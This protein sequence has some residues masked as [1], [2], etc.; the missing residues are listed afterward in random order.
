VSQR[1]ERRT[2]PFGIAL[3]IGAMLTLALFRLPELF[4]ARF[5]R[6][7]ALSFGQAGWAFRFL[8]MAALAQ[9]AYGGFVVLRTERVR[10]AWAARTPDRPERDGK[11]LS[12]ARV[13]RS[14]ASTAASMIFLTFVYGIAAFVVT[15]ER[16][17]YWLFVLIALG[18]AAWYFRRVGEIVTWLRFQPEPAYKDPN[19]APWVREPPDYCPPLTRGLIAPQTK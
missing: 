13:A 4:V 15:A 9:A 18:Q 17:G 5:E 6:E 8:V 16:G 19:K 3:A 11:R 12:R 7:R 14:A 2:A 1:I 10:K